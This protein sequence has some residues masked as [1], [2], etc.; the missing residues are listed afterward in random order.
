MPSTEIERSLRE[1]GA[2]FIESHERAAAAIHAAAASGMS[3][4][5]IARASGL[6]L[7]TVQAFLHARS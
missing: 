5:E 4:E 6:A 2:D 1:A 7:E 3:P